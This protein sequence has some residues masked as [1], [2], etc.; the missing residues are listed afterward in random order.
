[1]DNLSST[2]PGRLSVGKKAEVV[3]AV[4]G[5]FISV[6]YACEGCAI[7][8]K[9]FLAWQTA[10]DRFGQVLHSIEEACERH[11]LSTEEFKGW[12][13][14]VGQYGFPARRVSNTKKSTKNKTLKISA[15]TGFRE[16]SN[17]TS[18]ASRNPR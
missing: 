2:R 7:S 10:L 17:P 6:D 16:I 1:M 5:S 8:P 15:V 3:A 12:Q 9:G 18:Y 13:R 14:P 4:R 11:A